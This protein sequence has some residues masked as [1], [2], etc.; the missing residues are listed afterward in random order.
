[1]PEVVEQAELG[2][3]RG[4]D[5]ARA[6][7]VA[8]A[9]LEQR[10]AVLRRHAATREIPAAHHVR[11]HERQDR[12]DLPA[13]G[14]AVGVTVQTRDL[15]DLDLVRLPPGRARRLQDRSLGRL[16]IAR[17]EPVVDEDAFGGGPGGSERARVRRCEKDG[18]GFLHPREMSGPTVV[19]RRTT[20][21]KFS[22]ER[23]AFRELTRRQAGRSEVSR[24]AVADADAEQDA[25]RSQ[26]VHRRDRRR[27]HGGVPG[28]E[29]RDAHRNPRTPGA[30][31]QKRRRDPGSIALPGV[32]AMP[33]MS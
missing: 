29:V 23:H 14:V 13:G 31:S 10:P 7:A 26:E 16:H 28:D 33:T 15:P 21:Q 3:E 25:P 8:A 19:R 22:D 1:M 20:P 12:A 30:G 9:Q 17:A 18:A 32:S 5:L 4:V 2:D 11:R 6:R 27:R 24:A